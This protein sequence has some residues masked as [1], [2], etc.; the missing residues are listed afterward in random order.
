MKKMSSDKRRKRLA[1]LLQEGYKVRKDLA[2]QLGVDERTIR[3][4]IKDL[5]DSNYKFDE[6]KDDEKRIIIKLVRSGEAEKSSVEEFS[7]TPERSLRLFVLLKK[8]YNDPG[9]SIT[10]INNFFASEKEPSS[11]SQAHEVENTSLLK[12]DLNLLKKIDFIREEIISSHEKYYPGDVLIKPAILNDSELRELYKVIREHSSEYPYKSELLTAFGKMAAASISCQGAVFEDEDLVKL[13][14]R[15]LTVGQEVIHEPRVATLRGEI[16]RA[17]VQKKEISFYY[18]N[19]KRTVSPIGI[20]YNWN[21]DMWYLLALL[22]RKT[23]LSTWRIDRIIGDIEI[24][25]NSFSVPM[26]ID[27]DEHLNLSWGIVSGDPFKV[28]VKFEDV[29]NVRTKVKA[30]VET[31]RPCAELNDLFDGKGEYSGYFIYVDEV[32]GIDEFSNWLRQF[33][34]SAEVLEPVELRRRFL[35]TAKKI[36]KRYSVD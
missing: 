13:N 26:H 33:G 24:T 12:K 15:S 3:R 16:E 19:T 28:T 23:K 34:S 36:E 29:Y 7:L 20:I 5:V 21:N 30:M 27:A 31:S 35:R 4:D 14:Q 9:I 17:V 18:N 10:D 25:D 2:T 1:A 8:I 6:S 11:L 32:N 22:K